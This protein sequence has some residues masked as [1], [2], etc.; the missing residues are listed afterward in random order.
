MELHQARSFVEVAR[1][2][3]FS[4]AASKLFRTQPTITA[5]IQALEREVGTTLFERSSRGVRLTPSGQILLET[6]GPLLE[7]W[8]RVTPEVRERLDGVARGPVRVGAGEAAVLYLLP[9]PIRK[10]LDRSPQVEVVIRQQTEDQTLSMLREGDLDFGIR[11]LNA[12]PPDMTY[13]PF[14]TCDRML[15]SPRNHPVTRVRTLTLEALS[16]HR[17]VMPWKLSSTR[18]LIERSFE[19][20]GLPCN[21]ALE[22]GGWE[23]IKRYVGLGLG[24]AVIPEFCLP[25]ADRH[26]SSRSA[27]HLFGQDTYGLV[28][29]K[30]RSVAAAARSLAAEFRS[31][32][33]S[34]V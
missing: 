14:L 32:L 3:S 18:R 20:R 22:A 25:P 17:F 9:A 16:R 33:S 7:S 6:V 21:V 29:R 19:E 31:E 4:R 26:I 10:L 2:K 8:E 12:V 30:G 11:S 5:A 13:L 28:F 23:I 27:R 15:I 1:Q 34:Q 24:L